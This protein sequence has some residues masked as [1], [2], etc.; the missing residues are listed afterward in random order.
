MTK[1]IVIAFI[2]DS[3]P[4]SLHT[5]QQEPKIPPHRAFSG[6]FCNSS[7]LLQIQSFHKHIHKSNFLVL[8]HK[9]LDISIITV[10]D[11][12]SMSKIPICII[13]LVL[14]LIKV[15]EVSIVYKNH[16]TH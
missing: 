9:D 7:L 2:K 4:S 11:N 16:R 3:L 1:P 12:A 10:S 5:N 6:M 14:C 8:Q 15:S 13:K